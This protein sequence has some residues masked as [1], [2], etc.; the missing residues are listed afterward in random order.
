MRLPD[1]D[2]VSGLQRASLG[3]PVR[4]RRVRSDALEQSDVLRSMRIA[5]EAFP[6]A[7]SASKS[8]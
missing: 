1:L 3:E 2:I 8:R 4:E 7:A 5:A 6:P